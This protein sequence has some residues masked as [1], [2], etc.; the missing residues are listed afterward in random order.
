MRAAAAR[1][2]MHLALPLSA[3]GIGGSLA[4]ADFLRVGCFAGDDRLAISLV[5]LVPLA[6]AAL[7]SF[8]SARIDAGFRLP[9]WVTCATTCVCGS[10]IGATICAYLWGDPGFPMGVANGLAFGAAFSV[11]FSLVV[12]AARRT[13]Q[14][15][16]ASVVDR[17]DRLLVAA[18]VALSL[19]HI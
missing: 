3:L 13:G 10:L 15:R 18:V 5:A 9:A 2:T 8:F 1:R 14:A 4:V 6:S 19:I 12:A 17:S 11:A 7:G 16:H